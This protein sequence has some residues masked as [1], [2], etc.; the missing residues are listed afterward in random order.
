MT[1]GCGSRG[2]AN[3]PGSCTRTVILDRP[4]AGST[5]KT[6]RVQVSEM[7][8]RPHPLPNPGKAAFPK[9]P[10]CTLRCTAHRAA[11]CDRQAKCRFPGVDHLQ[12]VAKDRR[13][14]HRFL[15][16]PFHKCFKNSTGVQLPTIFCHPLQAVNT[17]KTAFSPPV[18]RVQY[19]VQC[20][21]E[22]TV[23]PWEKLLFRGWGGGGS[24]KNFR[25]VHTSR[26]FGEPS[27]RSVQNHRPCA[28]SG[29]VGHPPEYRPRSQNCPGVF[30]D[31]SDKKKP[32]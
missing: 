18:N 27:L 2:V 13:K 1:A 5:K 3:R 4:Q 19:S 30:F 15:G 31:C 6:T 20:T 8:W 7:F 24:P 21:V 26:F 32:R 16:S 11:H 22:Y 28:A 17:G 29:P 14:L 9:A 23:A 12:G 10:Q 25:N